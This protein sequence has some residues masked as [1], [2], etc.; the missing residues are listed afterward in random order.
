MKEMGNA[1]FASVWRKDIWMAV[2][3]IS[4]IWEN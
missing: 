4:E 2:A 3:V 1:L